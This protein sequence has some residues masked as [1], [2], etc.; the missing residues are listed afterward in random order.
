MAGDSFHQRLSASSMR[1]ALI[2]IKQTQLD[3]VF[4]WFVRFHH[5]SPNDQFPG[6]HDRR[7]HE[8]N[9]RQKSAG[10]WCGLAFG[11]VPGCFHA[12]ASNRETACLCF[13]P[14][15]SSAL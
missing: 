8:K 5:N 1:L 10:T 7:N 13:I 6:V 4:H 11:R 12:C 14:G 15:E 2:Q 3:I 9:K